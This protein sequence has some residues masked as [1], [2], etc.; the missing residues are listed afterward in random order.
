M[1]D[2]VVN[3]RRP[4]AGAEAQIA[5]KSV[6]A[7]AARSGLMF[8]VPTRSPLRRMPLWLIAGRLYAELG[9]KSLIANSAG[10]PCGVLA[11]RSLRRKYT[12]SR[13][14]TASS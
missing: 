10:H 4:R 5:E 9:C 1:T 3:R 12:A 11:A 6:K 2:A 8:F 7:D 14:D 13:Q